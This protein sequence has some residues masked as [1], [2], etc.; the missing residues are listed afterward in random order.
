[1]IPA[2]TPPNFALRA[3]RNAREDADS[4]AVVDPDDAVKALRLA[5]HAARITLPDLQADGCTCGAIISSPLVELGAVRPDVA[6]RLAEVIGH[7]AMHAAVQAAN[8][9]S[10]GE[11]L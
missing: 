9:R 2:E 5:L 7:G 11:R 1:M 4:G 3:V 10:R 8:A 6:L